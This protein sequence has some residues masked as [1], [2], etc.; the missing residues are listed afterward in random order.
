MMQTAPLSLTLDAFLQLPEMQPASEFINGKI[1]QKA[2]PQGEHS[3][4]QYKFCLTVN[5]VAEPAKIACA[6]P[7]LRCVFGGNAIIPDVAVFR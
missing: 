2:M 4:L 7:E 5:Q 6:F 3:R 1:I